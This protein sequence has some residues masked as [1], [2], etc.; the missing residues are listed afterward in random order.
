VR[1]D[2]NPTWIGVAIVL[3]LMLGA[4]IAWPFW[5]KRARDDIGSIIGAGVIFAFVVFFIAREYGEVEAITRGCI[6]ENIGCRFRPQPF[7]RYA[8][9]AAIG[10]GQVFALFLTGLAV[11]ERLRK[12][13]HQKRLG[14]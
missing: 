8:I 3:P 13:E 10:T 1:V 12:A 6:A 4:L 11:D 14:G 7:V 2:L 5:L 9:Y